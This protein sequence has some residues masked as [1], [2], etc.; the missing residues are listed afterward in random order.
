MKYWF[1]ISNLKLVA[2]KYGSFQ[3][4]RTCIKMVMNIMFPCMKHTATPAKFHVNL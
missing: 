2:I 4:I 3:T 1:W